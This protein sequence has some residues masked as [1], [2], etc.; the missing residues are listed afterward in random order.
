M[1]FSPLAAMNRRIPDGGRSGARGADVVGVLV[2]HNAGVD[3]YGQASA[4][5]REVS[6]Q[7]WITNAGDILPNVD[8]LRRAWTSGHPGYPAGAEA[9]HRFVTVEVSNN[10]TPGWG[11][12]DAALDALARLIGDVH[13][14]YNLGPVKRGFDRGV[15]V[16]R[17]FVAT[18]CPGPYMLTHL[19]D[20]IAAAETY[21][22][23]GSPEQ[24]LEMPL[25]Y[26]TRDTNKRK[27][28][29][30][31]IKEGLPQ[32][33]EH[34]DNSTAIS[35]GAGDHWGTAEIRVTG[36]P[37]AVVDIVCERYIWDG[38]KYASRVHITRCD[39]IAI[40]A[41]GVGLG[42]V[43]VSNRVP[44]DGSKLGILATVKRGGGTVTV[45]RFAAK[46][47]KQTV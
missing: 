43:P 21:R 40:G 28:K 36:K 42:A 19:G 34:G 5:G 14:R 31:Q 29:P 6:A 38:K 35:D 17:D 3:S 26:I 15:A 25:T 10:G 32:F 41:D 1:G 46:L 12:S 16:H 33:I 20:V 39:Q 30:Q 27:N 37:G 44:A 9:D 13:A 18:E 8:E 7:Y 47:H 4:P 23:G 24:D 22:T 2:H 45:E 11:I